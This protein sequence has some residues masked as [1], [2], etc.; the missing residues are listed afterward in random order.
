MAG[1]KVRLPTLASLLTN[2]PCLVRQCIPHST[3]VRVISLSEQQYV[4]QGSPEGSA[5]G[6]V[7]NALRTQGL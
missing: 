2:P 1:T 7:H 5:T 4:I 3:Q 6:A